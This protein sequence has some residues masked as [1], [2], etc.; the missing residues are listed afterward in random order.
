MSALPSARVTARALWISLSNRAFFKIFVTAS[1]LYTCKSVFSP[2]PKDVMFYY[3]FW[4][5]L[6]QI[7]TGANN[8]ALFSGHRL[9]SGWVMVA[10]AQRGWIR[11]H[12]TKWKGIETTKEIKELSLKILFHFH[13]ILI[14]GFELE[15]YGKKQKLTEDFKRKD[16][17]ALDCPFLALS[18]VMWLVFIQFLLHNWLRLQSHFIAQT[19]WRGKF[20][21]FHENNRWFAGKSLI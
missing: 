10:L 6:T 2:N 8:Q 15:F 5:Q 4:Y 17:P 9:C 12:G 16:S 13:F 18:F 21:P 1:L 19:P 7:D 20:G 3:A 11:P 14:Y